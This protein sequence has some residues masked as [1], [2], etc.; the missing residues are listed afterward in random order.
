M[1]SFI[2]L[3]TPREQ[4][5]NLEASSCPFKGERKVSFFGKNILIT[6]IFSELEYVILDQNEH[7][8]YSGKDGETSVV[9]RTIWMTESVSS[10]P[11]IS[12][13]LL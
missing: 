8:K 5:N 4:R 2:L 3:L 7:L 12:P 6:D 1:T 10:L 9:E 13:L 11:E